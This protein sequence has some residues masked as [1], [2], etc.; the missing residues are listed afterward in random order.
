MTAVCLDHFIE[1]QKP[2]TIIIHDQN[3]VGLLLF[4]KT[5]T[6]F[7]TTKEVLYLDVLQTRGKSF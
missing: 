5:F 6:I 2:I 3:P 1:N 7:K 4:N